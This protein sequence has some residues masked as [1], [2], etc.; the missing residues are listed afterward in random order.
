MTKS[1]DSIGEDS[2]RLHL[3][4]DLRALGGAADSLVTM[5]EEQLRTFVQL[6][7]VAL[8]NTLDMIERW[9]VDEY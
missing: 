2:L 1:N 4:R 9:P 8:N 5:P 3:A 7:A 6:I